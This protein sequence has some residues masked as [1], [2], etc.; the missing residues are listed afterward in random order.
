M[1]R[2]LLAL[3][4]VSCAAEP[5][6]VVDWRAQ[7]PRLAACKALAEATCARLESCAPR[8]AR[9]SVGT[10]CIATLTDACFE[11]A[12][13]GGSARSTADVRAC[14]DATR[15]SSCERFLARYPDVC[16]LPRGALADGVGCAFDE[17]C[18]SLHCRRPADSAC[19]VCATDTVALAGLGEP[20]GPM[21][22][23]GRLLFCDVSRCAP[24]R[25]LGESCG[26]V[27]QCDPFE[28]A[29]CNETYMC[30]TAAVAQLGQA[31]TFT[32]NALTL[33][34]APARC[35]D[36]RCVAAKRDGAACIE[37]HEC[38]G[39][40]GECIRG[41]CVRRTVELCAQK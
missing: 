13:L 20:C 6:P 18:A 5:A 36:D 25:K 26:G 12:G 9:I 39:Y 15:A 33:C 35:I 40:Y 21:V 10:A 11:T 14:A 1:A 29:I 24:K 8:S 2:F 23:C 4:L 19:G 16:E 41:H 22:P 38:E 7:S 34:E 30:Q 32:A 28:A 27:G 37:S 17:Q 31:C 3:L